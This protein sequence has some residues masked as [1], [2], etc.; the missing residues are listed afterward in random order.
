MKRNS[1]LRNIP[2]VQNGGKLSTEMS[3]PVHEVFAKLLRGLSG[4]RVTKPGH[5]RNGTG[6]FSVRC[7]YKADDGQVRGRGVVC[8]GMLQTM[9]AYAPGQCT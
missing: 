8:L 6:G 1:T 2:C 7:S 3:G 4:A 9:K 5:F